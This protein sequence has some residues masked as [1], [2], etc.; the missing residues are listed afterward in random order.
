MLR[1]SIRV[2]AAL[3]LA[4]FAFEGYRVLDA[5]RSLEARMTSLA[6]QT[7]SLSAWQLDAIVRVQDPSFRS[8]HGIE[9]P[10]PL[11]TTTITQS[12]VKKIFFEDFRPGFQKLEQTLVAALVVDPRVSKDQ[13]LRAFAQT[14]YFGTKDGRSVFGFEDAA[15]TWFGS[16]LEALTKDQFLSLLAML[17]SPKTL[18]PGSS[19]ASVRV[20][21]I[22]RLLDSKCI[23]TRISDIWLEQCSAQ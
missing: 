3:V 19:Q 5:A 15:K 12:L 13:Q 7:P 2:L 11:T 16:S 1:W 18:T 14:A 6:A 20:E 9:W 8:H 4:L 23:H 22:K 21:R 17:P 10:S